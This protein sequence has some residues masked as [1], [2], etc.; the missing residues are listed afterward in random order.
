MPLL[1]ALTVNEIGAAGATQLA[2]ALQHNSTLTDLRG[3]LMSYSILIIVFDVLSLL[4]CVGDFGAENDRVAR[5]LQ[6]NKQAATQRRVCNDMMV[7]VW[8]YGRS[9]F[10]R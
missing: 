2:N 1:S 8:R 7:M 5:L 3:M 4:F 6:R 10:F 9:H